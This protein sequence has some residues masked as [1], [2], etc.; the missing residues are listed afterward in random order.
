MRILH[1][2]VLVRERSDLDPGMTTIP[3]FVFP[4]ISSN[5]NPTI[6]P[7]IMCYGEIV[8]IG[9]GSVN[10]PAISS[11][12]VGDVVMYDLANVDHAYT[13]GTGAGHQLMSQKALAAVLV[14]GEPQALLDWVI[15]EQDNAAMKAYVG[16]IEV[17]DEVLINGERTD[18]ISDG[19]M[20]LI[21][22]RVHSVGKGRRYC[23]RQLPRNDT[24]RLAYDDARAPDRWIECESVPDVRKGDLMLFSPSASTRFRRNGQWY[25]ATA[26]DE[27]QGVPKE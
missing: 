22:E 26:W 5:I 9:P 21:V 11:L 8:A 10:Q 24:K 20:R 27:F 23:V 18:K 19:S 3:G 12:K 1:D 13:D 15:T 6:T 2:R 4:E 25:R 14:E 7:D 17:P 16:S